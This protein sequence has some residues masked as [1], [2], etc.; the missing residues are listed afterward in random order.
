MLLV[1]TAQ[2]TL[3]AMHNTCRHRGSILCTAEQGRFA[4]ERI[5]CPYHSWTY[6]LKGRLVA[7]PRRMKTPDF[8][9]RKFPLFEVA[10]KSWGG[11]VFITMDPDAE[12]QPMPPRKLSFKEQRELDALPARIEALEA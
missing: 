3:A 4:R 7:T 11:F 10:S 9:M 12:P 2:G 1:R 6:D 5:V 8:E